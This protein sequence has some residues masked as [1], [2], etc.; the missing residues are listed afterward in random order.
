[1]AFASSEFALPQADRC[2][3]K[4][5]VVI[6]LTIFAKG[7]SFA[8]AQVDD[9]P[10][11]DKIRP[12]GANAVANTVPSADQYQS[13]DDL[14]SDLRRRFDSAYEQ[15]H[16]AKREFEAAVSPELAV[17]RTR[18]D[19][20][21]ERERISNGLRNEYEAFQRGVTA[22]GAENV[23]EFAYWQRL[24]LEV[25]Q[26]NFF[27][28]CCADPDCRGLLAP[29]ARRLILSKVAA[30]PE[31]HPTGWDKI[32]ALVPADA[33]SLSE[34][35]SL[36]L[37][38]AWSQNTRTAHA[39]ELARL[40]GNLAPPEAVKRHLAERY[41]ANTEHAIFTPFV[42]QAE[43]GKFAE[44]QARFVQTHQQLSEI[45]P[46]WER[47]L[48]E[49]PYSYLA[50]LGEAPQPLPQGRW[51]LLTLNLLAVIALILILFFRKRLAVSH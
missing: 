25:N 35:Q 40:Q 48:K 43:Q 31:N 27:L 9:I 36:E 32:A 7:G 33:G 22:K 13:L 47:G 5:V 19:K 41:L 3:T 12:A 24:Y 38:L 17:A 4:I 10:P 2:A 49:G 51:W 37:L 50:E 1:M 11:V 26:A 34:E 44:L 29:F 16:E 14:P 45:W 23:L 18:L 28:D 6:A 30:P 8:F 21:R 46:A 39:D 20:A 15:Y 42:E